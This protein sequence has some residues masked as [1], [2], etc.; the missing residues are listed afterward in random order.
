MLHFLKQRTSINEK[1]NKKIYF[2]ITFEISR[3]Y[4]KNPKNSKNEMLVN[5]SLKKKIHKKIKIN[6]LEI[7]FQELFKP[8]K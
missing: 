1:N 5:V 2:K 4:L 7:P 6:L 3:G 8:I